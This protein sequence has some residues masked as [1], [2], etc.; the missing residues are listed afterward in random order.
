[1][2]TNRTDATRALNVVCIESREDLAA[3][4][5]HWDE[6]VEQA[7]NSSPFVTPAWQRSWLEAYGAGRRP[8]VLTA[9]RAGRLVAIW[10]LARRRR[11]AFQ[12]LEPIGAG[13][14]DWL[15]VPTLPGERDAALA[16]FVAWLSANRQRWDLLDVRDILAES[17]TIGCIER[18]ASD[19]ALHMRRERRTVAPYVS[20]SGTTWNAYL[21]SRSA[22]FRSTLKRRLKGVGDASGQFTIRVEESPD[23]DAIVDALAKV[24][25]KSWKAQ[26]GNRKL[27]TAIGRAFYRRF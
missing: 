15:D 7:D 26:D 12:V 17:A 24:E 14:S 16:A 27:T 8:F 5:R 20:L 9:R 10:P 13:R 19:G 18:L 22:N 25:A 2:R 11:G 1:M 3:I 23:P 6:L 4:E 21:A